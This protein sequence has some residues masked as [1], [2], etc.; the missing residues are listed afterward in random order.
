VG[1]VYVHDGT[2]RFGH[3]GHNYFAAEGFPRVPAGEIMP[4]F[5]GDEVVAELDR[6]IEAVVR[7]A[8]VRTGGMNFD[9]VVADGRV[10]LL[11][12]G[13]RCGGNYL[14]ELIRLS[15]D[16][17]LAAAAVHAALGDEYAVP[18]RHVRDARWAVSYVVNS[19]ESGRFRGFTVSEDIRP[20]LVR[21]VSFLQ[22]GDAVKPYV[23]GDHGV[24]ICLFALPGREEAEAV[25]PR[26]PA[27]V[28]VHV[29]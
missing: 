9:A 10:H 17:D 24:G 3:Y 2:L 29:G 14:S 7:A 22:P 23:R 27:C 6:Q 5:F 13:L 21:Q 4:G 18:A 16:V 28:R 12:V 1:D 25:Y 19:M 15:T 11:D 20:W 8:G 26:L